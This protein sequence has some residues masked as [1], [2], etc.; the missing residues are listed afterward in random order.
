MCCL[1]QLLDE[2]RD[3]PCFYYPHNLDFRGRAYPVHAHLHHLGSDHCR[4]VLEFAEG[5]PLG[6]RGLWWLKAHLA[7]V[8]AVGG[9]DKLPLAERVAF[10]EAHLGPIM[11]SADRPLDPAAWWRQA[12]DPFQCLAVCMELTRALR[13]PDPAAYVSH[14][15]VHQD[16]SCNGLQHYA[17]LGLDVVRA[18]F[19]T[20]RAN[21]WHSSL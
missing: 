13:S 8:F 10:T 6:K 21:P 3:E 14:L 19:P 5:K 4:G 16:G 20:P 9:V 15:P 12:E 17:A 18:F 1:L 2:F 11:E 7:N